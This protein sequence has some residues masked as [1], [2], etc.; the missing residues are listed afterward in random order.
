MGRLIGECNSV[1]KTIVCLVGQTLAHPCFCQFLP[2]HYLPVYLAET[3]ARAT[4]GTHGQT[5]HVLLAMRSL[6]DLRGPGLQGLRG[7]D[8]FLPPWTR[9]FL[10]EYS[11]QR[12]AARAVGQNLNSQ[13]RAR[14]A[15]QQFC[16]LQGIPWARSRHATPAPVVVNPSTHC[17]MDC[18]CCGLMLLQIIYLLATFGENRAKAKFF[19]FTLDIM[20][21]WT[22]T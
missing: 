5:R 14:R 12:H 20:L 22:S 7:Y 6:S 4:P 19:V 15:R 3:Q 11:V 13:L 1:L 18:I 10:I 9:C 2:A 17:I 8:T 16:Q 21:C